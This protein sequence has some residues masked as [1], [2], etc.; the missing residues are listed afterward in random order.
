MIKR[1][2]TQALAQLRTLAAEASANLYS[3]IGLAAE[4]LADLDWI[5]TIFSG[6]DHK[7]VDAIQHEYFRDLGGYISLGKLL[8]MYARIDAD[9]WK[10]CKY[11]VAAVEV[12]YDELSSARPDSP[13]AK[14]TCW[15]AIAEERGA[16]IEQ[17]ERQI[18]ELV[19]A[20]ESLRD[21][22]MSLRAASSRLEGRIEE[23]DR[24][25]G[26]LIGR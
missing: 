11:D 4:V 7:A 17:L 18:A 12:M 10:E 16:K 24:R 13:P 23:M 3:R 9:G 5:A 2:T 8:Q 14:R 1:S 6:S 21:E 25:T 19:A 22:N 20:N 26:T 15:K